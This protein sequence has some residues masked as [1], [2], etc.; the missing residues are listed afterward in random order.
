LADGR[1]NLT[2][3]ELQPDLQAAIRNQIDREDRRLRVEPRRRAC[4]RSKALA[5]S[6]AGDQMT[7]RFS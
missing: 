7:R 3:V 5:T 2:V 1:F 4:S 6:A